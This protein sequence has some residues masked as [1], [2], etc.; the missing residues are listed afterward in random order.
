MTLCDFPDEET[1]SWGCKAIG[2]CHK[3]VWYGSEEIVKSM[4]P[5][6]KIYVHDHSAMPLSG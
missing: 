1:E 2:Q 3:D 6:P 4:S 5:I